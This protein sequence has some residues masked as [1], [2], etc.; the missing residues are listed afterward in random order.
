MGCRT[1]GYQDS[2]SVCW[3]LP[4]IQYQLDNKSHMIIFRPFQCY[5]PHY[6]LLLGGDSAEGVRANGF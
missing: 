5:Y 6:R 4:P 1:L 3:I 2:M